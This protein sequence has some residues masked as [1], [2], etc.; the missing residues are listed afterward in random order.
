[1]LAYGGGLADSFEFSVSDANQHIV[2]RQARS[3]GNAER[4]FQVQGDRFNL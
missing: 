4:R 3:V 2:P 1:M